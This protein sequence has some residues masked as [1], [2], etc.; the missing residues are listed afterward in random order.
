VVDPPGLGQSCGCDKSGCH[1]IQ[2]DG[3]CL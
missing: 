2:C 3:T 1:T